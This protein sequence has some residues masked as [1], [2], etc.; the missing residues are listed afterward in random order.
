MGL[1]DAVLAGVRDEVKSPWVRK[2]GCQMLHSLS[3]KYKASGLESAAGAF[4]SRVPSEVR[5]S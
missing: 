3:R 4:G 1:V 5:I 2:K